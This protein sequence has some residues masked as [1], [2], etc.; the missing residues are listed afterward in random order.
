MNVTS[1][2]STSVYH[3][4]PGTVNPEDARN[5]LAAAQ[6]GDEAAASYALDIDKPGM[7]HTTRGSDIETKYD[8]AKQFDEISGEFGE[9]VI[10]MVTGS[11]NTMPDMNVVSDMEN[12]YNELKQ[13][14]MDE[15]SGDEKE[16]RLADLEKNYQFFMKEN[17]YGPLQFGIGVQRALIKTQ[18]RVADAYEKS[19]GKNGKAFANRAFM[20]D[21]SGLKDSTEAAQKQ[22]DLMQQMFDKFKEIMEK[23][24]GK[25]KDG[26]AAAND[27]VKDIGKGLYG[28]HKTASTASETITSSGNK[29]VQELWELLNK[30]NSIYQSIGKKAAS[31]EEKYKSY[32]DGRKAVAGMDERIQALME[33]I[34]I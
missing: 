27:M 23:S 26:I 33:K 22:I 29:D 18:S 20:V 7:Y 14:I 13:Q 32:L 8:Y 1:I 16:D 31:D 4:M 9:N 25:D 17:V 15:Y 3:G 30:K 10:A 5:K 28:L 11:G 6:R 2:Q 19:V 12:K 21:L 24:H 34:S